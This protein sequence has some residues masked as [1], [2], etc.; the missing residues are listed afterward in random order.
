VKHWLL[1]GCDHPFDLPAVL[2]KHPATS[3]SDGAAFC[4]CVPAWSGTEALL[5]KWL[6]QQ[7]LVIAN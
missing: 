5:S 7:W 6:W 1:R 2:I 4:H 3:S